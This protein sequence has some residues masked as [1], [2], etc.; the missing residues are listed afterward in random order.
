MRRESGWSAAG[1]ACGRRAG[2]LAAAAAGIGARLPLPQP[3]PP[4]FGGG[5]AE[6]IVVEILVSEVLA[7][8]LLKAVV[9]VHADGGVV[10]VEVF[11]ELRHRGLVPLT[12]GLLN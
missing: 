2:S 4:S 6:V 9:G 10:A 1:G 3:L 7:G 5:F 12:D 8:Q 11:H